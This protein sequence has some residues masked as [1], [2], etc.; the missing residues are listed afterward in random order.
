[1]STETK[2]GT[3]P[4]TDAGRDAVHVAVVPMT[5][6]ADMDPGTV[7]CEA[8]IPVFPGSRRRGVGVVDPFRLTPVARGERYWLCL[9]PGTITGLRHVWTHPAFPE[10]KEKT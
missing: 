8:G 6:A 5:A 2:L 10:P 4:P 9:Y 3:P 1:M 7:V